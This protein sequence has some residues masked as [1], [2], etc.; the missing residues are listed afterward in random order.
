MATESAV[1]AVIR[2]SRPS[3]RNPHD[4]VAFAVHASFLAAGFSLTAT[5][6]NA[7]SDN[8]PIGGEEVGIEG[9]NELEDSYGFL[10]SK[11][12][13]GQKKNVLVR[14]LV[15]GDIL[16]IDGLNLEG[17]QKEPFNL[18]IKVNDYLYDDGNMTSNYGELYKDLKGLIKNLNSGILAKLEPKVGSSGEG[19]HKSTAEPAIRIPVDHQP[20]NSGIVYPP[21]P[22]FE[23]NDALPGPG[24]GFYPERSSSVGGDML[25]GPNDPRWFGSGEF[26]GSFGGLPGVPPGAHFDPYGPPGVPGFVPGHFARQPQ[27]PGSPKKAHCPPQIKLEWSCE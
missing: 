1:M 9:W 7:L 5:G 3:F 23:F 16:A 18:Q 21:V 25:V 15:I 11:T 22:P 4:K 20:Q 12:E 6:K 10:Y 27:Q 19:L 17:E 2:A 26:S 24:S 13:K 8:P 14:C